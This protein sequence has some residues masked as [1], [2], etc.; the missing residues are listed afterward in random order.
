MPLLPKGKTRYDAGKE[1]P[2]RSSEETTVFP[3]ERILARRRRPV[4]SPGRG[5]ETGVLHRFNAKSAR[6]FK[7]VT[8]HS[9]Y[10]TERY[11]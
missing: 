5:L 9:E 8:F 3:S 10:R 6:L 1:Y 7:R 4:P 2:S 11:G